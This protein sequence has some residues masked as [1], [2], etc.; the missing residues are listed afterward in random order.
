LPITISS[1]KID[2]NCQSLEKLHGNYV[3]SHPGFYSLVISFANSVRIERKEGLFSVS[4][5][6]KPRRRNMTR[7]TPEIKKK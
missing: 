6:E 4:Y 1:I 7:C 5:E 3:F 2:W